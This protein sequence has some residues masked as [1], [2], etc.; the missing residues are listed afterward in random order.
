MFNRHSRMAL[1]AGLLGAALSVPALAADVDGQS[2]QATISD[3]PMVATSAPAQSGPVVARETLA[4]TKTAEVA[5]VG[6][7]E[8][9][10]SATGLSPAARRA[11]RAARAASAGSS[12]Y[13]GYRSSGHPLILGVRF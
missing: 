9:T 6:G 12:S 13:G 2:A 1:L 11:A 4:P 10:R 3:Q 8:P 5:V 7:S